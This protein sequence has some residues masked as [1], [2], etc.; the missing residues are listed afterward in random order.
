MA[1]KENRSGL[2]LNARHRPKKCIDCGK[3]FVPLSGR[4]LRCFE[5]RGK[6]RYPSKGKLA[7]MGGRT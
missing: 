1:K 3:V 5:C 7:S 2:T 6:V 4:A